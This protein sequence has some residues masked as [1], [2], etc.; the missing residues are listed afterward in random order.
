[1]KAEE[2]V[3]ANLA[4]ANYRAHLENMK[5]R[6]RVQDDDVLDLTTIDN[7]QRNLNEESDSNPRVDAKDARNQKVKKQKK[8]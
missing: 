6:E 4:E 3:R 8:K 7:S 2:R 1:M 5:N